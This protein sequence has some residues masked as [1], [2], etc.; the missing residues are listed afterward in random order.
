LKRTIVFLLA[1]T[2]WAYPIHAAS[3]LA[4]TNQEQP[5]INYAQFHKPVQQVLGS[6]DSAAATKAHA[7]QS[8]PVIKPRPGL[9]DST[10]YNGRHYSKEE[11]Q[12]LISR[13]SQQYGISADVPLCIAQKESGFTQFS[14]NKRSTARGVFQY[15]KGTWQGTDEGKAGLSVFDADANVRAAIK[16]MS[17]HKSTSPWTT[18]SHCPTLQFL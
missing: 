11:I 13:Y 15:L 7:S 3:A 16:Y 4:E 18:A 9:P 14:S 6:N 1:L 12:A 8:D 10:Q 2:A 5:F 17:I